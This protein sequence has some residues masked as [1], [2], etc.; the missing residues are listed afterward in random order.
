MG[1]GMG[2]IG[3][4]L[5][6]ISGFMPSIS[7]ETVLFG[8]LSF[9]PI[10]NLLIEILAIGKSPLYILAFFTAFFYFSGLACGFYGLVSWRPK[11]TLYGGTLGLLY[12]FLCYFL[13]YS[14]IRSMT[15]EPIASIAL[16]LSSVGIGVFVGL[17]GA[18]LMLYS[19]TQRRRRR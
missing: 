9:L 5:L 14:Y 16:Q 4:F 19:S 2:W 3:L 8:S 13:I 12:S 17:F 15:A 10:L 11:Y 6:L 1:R 18:I 7:M